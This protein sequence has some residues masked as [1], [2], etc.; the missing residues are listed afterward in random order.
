VN[1][2]PA[3]A[4]FEPLNVAAPERAGHVFVTEDPD[5]NGTTG[6]LQLRAVVAWKDVRGSDERLE[7]ATRRA[8]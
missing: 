8:R 6:L 3:S 2:A 4:A 7:L 5:G 1:L